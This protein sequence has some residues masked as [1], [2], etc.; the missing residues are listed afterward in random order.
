MAYILMNAGGGSMFITGLCV[1]VSTIAQLIFLLVY[2]GISDKK[3]KS[4]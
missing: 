3:L 2:M 4:A 1:P